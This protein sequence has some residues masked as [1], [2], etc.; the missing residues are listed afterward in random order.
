M[1]QFALI[2][3]FKFVGL[4]N[5]NTSSSKL[6]NISIQSVGSMQ[7][8]I[9][10]IIQDE[11]GNIRDSQYFDDFLRQPSIQQ[12]MLMYGDTLLDIL[13]QES[14][15]SP[16]MRLNRVLTGNPHAD[17]SRMIGSIAESL[18]VKLCNESKEANRELGKWARGGTQTTATLD[19]YIAVATG[20]QKTKTSFRQWY[21]PSDTQKDV[22]WIKKDDTD[23]QLLCVKKRGSW[24]SESLR[25][26]K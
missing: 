25:G 13:T 7:K 9:K 2:A 6:Y 3:F 21:N 18:V 8:T 4:K 14:Q 19:S 26:Y 20:S 22:I 10:V 15:L 23:H 12:Q 17:A 24:A 16:S 5:K 11:D 1:F